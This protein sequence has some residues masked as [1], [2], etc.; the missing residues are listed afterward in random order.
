MRLDLSGLKCPLPALMTKRALLKAPP[1]TTID[2][3][4]DDPLAYIDIPHMCEREGFQ[5]IETRRN[6]DAVRLAIRRN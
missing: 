3:I 5:V 2:V 1:G 4:A 6:G